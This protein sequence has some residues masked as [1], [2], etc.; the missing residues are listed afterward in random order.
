MASFRSTQRIVE[1]NNL[2]DNKEVQG[3]LQKA[4]KLEAY[5]STVGARALEAIQAKVSQIASEKVELCTLNEAENVLSN[6]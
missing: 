2:E 6:G 3:Y 4:A 5:D 1:E